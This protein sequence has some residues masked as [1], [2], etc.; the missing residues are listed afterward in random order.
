VEV[1]EEGSSLRLGESGH[2]RGIKPGLYRVL[3]K[4]G[5]LLNK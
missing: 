4:E 2:T 3:E 1:R 5:R